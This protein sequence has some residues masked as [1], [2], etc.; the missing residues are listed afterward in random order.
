M[1]KN[2]FSNILN[3][4]NKMKEGAGFNND[5]DKYWSCETDKAGNGQATIRFLPS[6][7]G[8][9]LPFVRKYSHG[10]QVGAK[11]FIDDCRTTIGDN[12]PVC[13]ANNDLWNTGVK[14]NQEIVRKRKRK[15]S[16][17]A[18]ILVVSDPKNP[19]NEGKVFMFKFGKKI[20]DKIVDKMQPE[21]EDEEAIN[22]FD[23]NEGCD[24]KLKI[25]RVEGYANFDKSEFGDKKDRS[26]EIEAVLDDMED[27]QDLI[28]P[29]KFKSYADQKKRLDAVLG[30]VKGGS[31]AVEDEEVD[32]EDL[33]FLKKASSKPQKPADEEPPFEVEDKKPSPSKAKPAASSDDDEDMDFFRNL[34]DED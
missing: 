2:A 33:A 22:P 18:N 16:F 4:V 14:E 5:K 26:D 9:S 3:A 21:F 19:D 32:D 12:C 31:R 34:A 24:F 30:A 15:Q 1:N 8:E 25:R 10:F 23:P 29:E 27:L 11:W 7:D 13:E 6:K 28:A 17:I 20:F